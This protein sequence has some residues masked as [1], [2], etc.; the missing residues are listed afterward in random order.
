MIIRAVAVPGDGRLSF[1]PGDQGNQLAYGL[2]VRGRHRQADVDGG[3]IGLI[4]MGRE[5]GLA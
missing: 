3:A 5:L 4:D 1:Q 2:V